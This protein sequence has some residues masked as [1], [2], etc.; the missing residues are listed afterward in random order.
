ML[1]TFHETIMNRCLEIAYN[2]FGQTTPNPM[3]GC[4]L[5]FENKIIGEGYHQKAGEAHAEINAINSV[6][7][8]NLIPLST[9]YVSL[10]PC[11]HYGKTP[12]CCERIV[13]EGIKKVVVGTID[14][15]ADVNGKGISFLQQNNVEVVAPLLNDA[16]RTLNSRFFTFH[17]KHRPYIILKWAQSADGF[18]APENAQQQYAI[19]NTFSKTLSH[20]WRTEEQAILVGTKTA[21]VDNPQLNARLWKGKDPIRIVIDKNLD[22]PTSHHLLDGSVKTILINQKKETIENNIDYVKL[23]FQENPATQILKVLYQFKIQSVIIEGG[24]Q[25]LQYFIQSNLWD[26]AR[27]FS[28]AIPLIRGI[29]APEISISHSK[30]TTIEDDTLKIFY[31]V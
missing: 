30:I 14:T 8:K 20:K 21:I 15:S 1:M 29:K 22:V 13:Q 16:C 26:E 25:T 2:A 3:V 24:T 17:E 23:N 5:V 31:N 11:S 12:P 9:L 19:S 7:N 18:I 27:V 6:E 10:E 28:A 4:V